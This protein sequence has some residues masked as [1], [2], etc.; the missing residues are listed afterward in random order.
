MS[1]TAHI[2]T[3]TSVVVKEIADTLGVSVDVLYSDKIKDETS[4]EAYEL[5]KIWREIDSPQARQ[6]VLNFARLEAARCN[7]SSD[8]KT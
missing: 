6:R 4:A 5:L 2:S 1:D 8:D 3:K 7:A